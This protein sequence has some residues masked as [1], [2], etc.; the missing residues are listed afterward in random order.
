MFNLS[1]AHNIPVL[2]FVDNSTS[3]MSESSSGLEAIGTVITWLL[4]FVSD[5]V[6]TIASTPMLLIPIGFVVMYGVVRLAK[7]FIGTRR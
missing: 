1:V 7:S 4:G 2:F 5:V 3:V 6:D